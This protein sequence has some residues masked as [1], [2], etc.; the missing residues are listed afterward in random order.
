VDIYF[1]SARLVHL[2]PGPV[3]AVKLATSG[4]WWEQKGEA[5]AETPCGPLGSRTPTTKGLEA[6]KGTLVL[7]SEVFVQR[8]ALLL[9]D[10]LL[11]F[12]LG[13]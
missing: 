1:P 4:T 12:P 6:V 9:L 8:R 10:P 3:N 7:L 11:G 2:S 13:A 5:V